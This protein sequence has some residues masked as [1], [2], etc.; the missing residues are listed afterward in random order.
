MA[1][2]QPQPQPSQPISV[3]QDW[4]LALPLQ[5]QSVML[6]ACRGPDG[7]ARHHLCKDAIRAM[8]ATVLHNARFGRALTFGEIGDSFI[9]LDQFANANGWTQAIKD[10]FASLEALP[11][12]FSIHF[13]HAA[14][15]A[16]YKHPDARF[17]ERW[18]AFYHK[19]CADLYLNPETEEQMDTRLNDWAQEY[20]D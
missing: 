3:V 7:I 11:H 8:R 16:G 4:L 1:V 17:R 15:V 13:L 18:L 12:H 5:Q 6:L 19:G 9:S 10:F 14:E 20:W 2:L